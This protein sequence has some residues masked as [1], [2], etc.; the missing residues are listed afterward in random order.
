MAVYSQKIHIIGT[1][2]NAPYNIDLVTTLAETTSPLHLNYANGSTTV[3]TSLIIRSKIDSS[4]RTP[5][6]VNYGNDYCVP[7]RN[8]IPYKTIYYTSSGTFTVPQGIT[9]IRITLVGGGGGGLPGSSYIISS[10]NYG[11][12]EGER[13]SSYTKYAAYSGGSSSCLGLA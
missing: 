13:P 5:L 10:E 7:K 9:R 8:V 11:G 12:G 6:N 2:D 3:Y 1:S 4:L